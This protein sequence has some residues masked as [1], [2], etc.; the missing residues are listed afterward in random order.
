[1]K[2]ACHRSIETLIIRMTVY[3]RFFLSQTCMTINI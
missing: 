3:F 2:S 1:M